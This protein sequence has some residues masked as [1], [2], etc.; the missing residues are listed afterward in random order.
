LRFVG[1]ALPQNYD[2]LHS[3]R[4]GFL[5][6]SGMFGKKSVL[7]HARIDV[8]MALKAAPRRMTVSSTRTRHG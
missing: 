3:R 8:V 7:T 6:V 4:W 2:V 1:S 5:S